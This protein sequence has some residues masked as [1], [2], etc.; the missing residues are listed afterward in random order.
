MASIAQNPI[1]TNYTMTSERFLVLISKSKEELRDPRF[2]SSQYL[3]QDGSL[4]FEKIEFENSIKFDDGFT[5]EYEL[6]FITCRFKSFHSINCTFEKQISFDNCE[7]YNFRVEK[8]CQFHNQL[9]IASKS[10]INI[11][12]LNGGIYKDP[13][14]LDNSTITANFLIKGDCIFHAGLFLMDNIFETNV[15]IWGGHFLQNLDFLG[16]EFKNGLSFQGVNVERPIT[17]SNEK[18]EGADL[19]FNGG[20]FN[21]VFFRGGVYDTI[22]F[23]FGEFKNIEFSNSITKIEKVF[24][25]PKRDLIIN[26]LSIDFTEIK[27][28]TYSFES[29][30]T[31]INNT[32]TIN[33]I[34]LKGVIAKETY[35][36]FVNFNTPE[37]I[38]FDNLTNFG[39][40][41]FKDIKPIVKEINH[42]K[43]NFRSTL[44]KYFKALCEGTFEVTAFFLGKPMISVHN[45]FQIYNSD[46][47]KTTFMGSDFSNLFLDFQSSKITE[48]FIS[49][50][51]LP[52]EPLRTDLKNL[53]KQEKIKFFNQQRSAFSQIKKIYE[54]RGDTVTALEYY[55]KEMDI[56]NK[57]PAITTSELINLTLSKFSTNHGTNWW[58]GLIS[59][60]VA[61]SILFFLFCLSIKIYPSCTGTGWSYFWDTAFPSYF[62]FLNPLHKS[63][64][65]VSNL[66]QMRSKEANP[67]ISMGTSFVDFM[68]KIIITY[69]QFQ[70]VQAF[71]KHGKK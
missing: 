16:S 10:Q 33:S 9:N 49:D 40:I 29:S 19:E 65:I 52:K 7:I 38:I 60:I 26:D 32:G 59:T 54:N 41:Y 8:N 27:C 57:N 55:A 18:F 39:N 28:K 56:L 17:F 68:S 31:E 23:H 11:F 35:C 1:T 25:S 70:L 48:A 64:E 36:E 51:I 6:E 66:C 4:K 5:C 46:L 58:W 37:T 24:F 43:T 3:Q 67:T 61:S 12:Q 44:L 42:V 22:R 45:V 63:K 15:K 53:S 21:S 71:R 2:T 13:V 20:K 14:Y 34:R 50:S 47:G 69:C 62:E 30:G